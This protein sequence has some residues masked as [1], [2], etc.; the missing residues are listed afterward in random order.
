MSLAFPLQ[1]VMLLDSAPGMADHHALLLL[2]LAAA[3]GLLLR[4]AQ[5]PAPAPAPGDGPRDATAATA[6]ACGACCAL[7]LWIS[8]EFFPLA[9][10]A[11]AALGLG[12]IL[13]GGGR[14]AR[15]AW[16]AAGLAAGAA[17]ALLVER[18]PQALAELESDRLSILHVLPCVVLALFWAAV[19]S[20]RVAPLVS[21]RG[22][23]ALAAALV[24]LPVAALLA[25]V[26]R[27]ALAEAALD[28]D[29]HVAPFFDTPG[30][31]PLLPTTTETAAAF[32]LE[33]GAAL[34][35]VPWLLVRL[36]R[37]GG[38]PEGEGWLAF[39]ALG[40]GQLAGALR[41]GRLAG[42]AELLLLVPLGAAAAQALAS[43]AARPPGVRRVLAG[44]ART[45][46]I[47]LG[48]LAVGAALVALSPPEPD[49]NAFRPSDL[50]PLY[51]MLDTL[52]ERPLTILTLP[53]DA[54]ELLY[55]TRHRTVAYPQHRGLESIRDCLLVCDTD[56]E[57]LAH[58][59]VSARAVDL[60]VVPAA[61][62]P[63]GGG[64][65]ARCAA[66]DCPPWLRQIHADA[67][68]A[69]AVLIY[70]VDR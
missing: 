18:G 53:G 25:W 57:E 61:S 52:G 45:A 68:E 66:G 42:G 50:R 56:D 60:I 34:V 20:P 38:R 43:L 5:P 4:T 62:G 58:R 40:L 12:W 48:P 67:A 55:R 32:L 9:L 47:L 2:V 33:L 30:L 63:M 17:V 6:A 46:A 70:A 1:L 26:A 21:T 15:N 29:P 39:A 24:A 35:A 16:Q 19:A 8:T 64:V 49:I 59:I 11:C 31:R 22:R 69:A 27:V 41:L 36:R 54:P 3:L 44:A 23:R 65:L 10:L 14:A 37:A 28:T 51:P 13:H 7:G